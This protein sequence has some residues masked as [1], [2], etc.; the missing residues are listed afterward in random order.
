M[1]PEIINQPTYVVVLYIMITRE[2]MERERVSDRSTQVTSITPYSILGI[3]ASTASQCIYLFVL[4]LTSTKLVKNIH[5]SNAH[6][7]DPGNF[8]QKVYH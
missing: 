3:T 6:T 5:G 1:T 4:N 8:T 7:K 2:W